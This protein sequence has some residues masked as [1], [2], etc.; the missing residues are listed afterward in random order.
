MRWRLDS[1]GA[2]AADSGQVQGFS[3]SE[4]VARLQTYREGRTNRDCGYTGRG[5]Q[6]RRKLKT[7]QLSGIPQGEKRPGPS[8]LSVDGGAGEDQLGCSVD[9]SRA[10][11]GQ[12]VGTSSPRSSQAGVRT[13]GAD[14]DGSGSL[15]VSPQRKAP[16]KNVARTRPPPPTPCVATRDSCKPPAP[17]CCDPCAFCQCRFFR[18]ACSCRVLNPTC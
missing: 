18:S 5:R 14:V 2:R 10:G 17:A 13:S 6:Q 8:Q 1:K 11:G 3:G 12:Q 16:M 9:M 7:V 4:E 15:G